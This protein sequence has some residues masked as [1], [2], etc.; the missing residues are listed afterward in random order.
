M[1]TSVRIVGVSKSRALQVVQAPNPNENESIDLVVELVNTAVME[2]QRKRLK[3]EQD[4]RDR[5]AA[6]KKEAEDR[7]LR[8]REMARRRR[9]RFVNAVLDTAL[10]GFSIIGI[11]VTIWFMVF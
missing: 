7:L 10:I 2:N 5:K 11:A 4:E 1:K 8:Q 6:A 3:A 9:V